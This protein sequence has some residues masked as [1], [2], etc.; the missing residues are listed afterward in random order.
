[1]VQ[2]SVLLKIDLIH[3]LIINNDMKL[4][5]IS[6]K[7]R[8]VNLIAVIL[9]K[10]LLNILVHVGLNPLCISLADDNI[11]D[12]TNLL[13]QFGCDVNRLGWNRFETNVSTSINHRTR[14]SSSYSFDHPLNICLRRL[15]QSNE[16]T[17]IADHCSHKQNAV[18]LIRSGANVYA[19]YDQG[20]LYPLLLAVQTGDK[21]IVQAILREAKNYLQWNIIEPLICACTKTYYDIV[22][23]L[24]DAG[25]NPNIVMNN[26]E[27]R[28]V[29][30][31][32][33]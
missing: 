20:S 16:N 15:C 27:I 23:I 25:F 11:Y 33:K 29:T 10:I 30:T 24:I 26:R 7:E 9:H 8:I 21:T 12:Y 14:N 17:T 3:R 32:K 4:S 6:W 18:K 5:N 28:T 1:M 19:M 13:L 31:R 2:L 22:L